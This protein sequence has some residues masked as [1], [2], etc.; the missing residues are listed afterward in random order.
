MVSPLWELFRNVGCGASSNSSTQKDHNLFGIS[1]LHTLQDSASCSYRMDLVPNRGFAWVFDSG[2]KKL[3]EIANPWWKE[4]ANLWWHVHLIQYGG[5]LRWWGTANHPKLQH[6][7]IETHGDL[8]IP[9]FKKP[10]ISWSHLVVAPAASATES[11]AA[12]CSCSA[13][14]KADLGLLWSNVIKNQ[15][16]KRWSTHTIEVTIGC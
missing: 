10:G 15:L 14:C 7:S 4:T 1:Y 5:F 2:G 9:R 13:V 8:G 16:V 11:G 3:Q 12:E 6:V